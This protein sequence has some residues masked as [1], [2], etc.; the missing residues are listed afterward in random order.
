MKNGQTILTNGSSSSYVRT[1]M[2]I[3]L[4]PLDCLLTEHP[5]GDNINF[6]NLS[7]FVGR[8]GLR[9]LSLF[10]IV[11]GMDD[12]TNMGIAD[13][14]NFKAKYPQPSKSFL[15]KLCASDGVINTN[16]IK[17]MLQNTYN[18]Q[19]LKYDK[20][21]AWDGNNDK[22]T[23]LFNGNTLNKYKINDTVYVPISNIDW[24]SINKDLD[25]NN[26]PNTHNY[27]T[28][29]Y[30]N[31]S[32]D[33]IDPYYNENIFRIDLNYSNYGGYKS[34]M[35]LNN[36]PLSYVDNL[37]LEFDAKKYLERYFYDDGRVFVRKF[38]ENKKNVITYT[39]AKGTHT[40]PSSKS[41]TLIESFADGSD[42]ENNFNEIKDGEDLIKINRP[43]G[44]FSNAE[45]EISGV[46]T[47]TIPSFKGITY[48]NEFTPEY[49]I[50][51]QVKYYELD[52]NYAKAL[53]FLDSLKLK[54]EG[55]NFGGVR[56]DNYALDNDK[57]ITA[58][59]Q[60]DDEPFEIMPY[61]GLLLLGG[62]FWREQQ[63]IDPIK[64]FVK[65]SGA[66]KAIAYSIENSV[67]ELRQD[68]KNYLILEFKKWV[69]NEFKFYQEQFEI[70]PSIGESTAD[71]V[72]QLIQQIKS[73]K[74]N[75]VKYLYD[76]VS[77]TFFE[78]YISFK[79]SNGNL[80]LFNRET[81]VAVKML[82]NFYIQPCMV[83]KPTKYVS[84]KNVNYV[85][86]GDDYEKYIN[87]FITK[88]RE[89][90]Q[91]EYNTSK[92]EIVTVNPINTNEHI[93]ISLYKY[94][95]IL[96]DKWLSGTEESEW[97]LSK[98]YENN[99]Q[100]IDSYYN[101]VGDRT[102][103][104]IKQF[105]NDIIY[106]QKENGYSLLSFLSKTYA[107][108]RFAFH[109]V[110]NFMNLNN[111]KEDAKFQRL[112]DA[113]PYNEIDFN[114]INIHPSFIVM[115]TYEYSSKLDIEGG[116]YQDDSFDISS[117]SPK[118]LPTPISTK[119]L[120]NGYRVPAFGVTYGKQYQSYFKDI[121]ISMD[122]PMVTEQSIKAQFMIA[123]MH[124][125]NGE[126]GKK[127]D[128]LGQDLYTIYSNNSYTC[129]VKMMGCAWIQP[130]MYFQLFNV[131]MFRGAYLI[132]KVS[133]HIEPGNMETTFVG[134]RMAKTT[135]Q[136]VEKPL[137]LND[138]DQVPPYVSEIVEGAQ[139]EVTNDC[140]YKFFNPLLDSD[141]PRMTST[142]LG[143]SPTQ[144][145][146]Y[147][148]NTFKIPTANFSSIKQLIGS[149]VRSEAENQDKLG[150]QLVAT[151]LFNRYM[152]HGKDLTKVI[153]GKQH[154]Y[155]KIAYQNS[156][157]CTIAEDIFTKSPII[158]RGDMTKVS[159]QVPIL[160]QGQPNGLISEPITLTEHMLKSMDGYCT[161]RGYDMN[162]EG[163]AT[164]E[165]VGWWHN[166]KYVCQHDTST[167]A[168]GHVFVAGAYQ[169]G[170]TEYWQEFKENTTN[171]D[172][173]PSKKAKGLFE[174]I[175]ST[176]SFSNNIS[177]DNI[178]MEK[179]KY[180]DKDV[181]YITVTPEK[182]MID[183][184]DAIVNTYYDY[185]S[186]CNWIVKNDANEHPNK[187][188]VK[189]ENNATKR[190]ISI[191]KLNNN[192][193]INNLNQY[194]GLSK[195]FYTTLKKKYKSIDTNNKETFKVECPNFSTLISK[196]VD[197]MNKVNNLLGV[198]IKSCDGKVNL[199]TI[200]GYS[201]DGDN[202]PSNYG[203][204]T[205]P[206]NNDFNP[207]KAADYAKDNKT[208]DNKSIG[209]CATYVREAFQIG[210]G[211]GS[212]SDRPMSACAYSKFMEAW[213][214]TEVYRGFS[215]SIE[216]YSPQK[217]D[218]SV[219]AGTSAKPHGH[220][221]IYN[222]GLWY[223]DYGDKDAYCYNAD[224]GRPYIIYR[225]MKGGYNT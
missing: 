4:T 149:V 185:F 193:T 190:I 162:Y 141:S 142:E 181:F 54:E 145:E 159:R 73:D 75:I 81:S 102:Y 91:N 111:P 172:S 43:Y 128:F 169:K 7:D 200:D 44:L 134:T 121:N 138:N 42:Y 219:I 156:D 210:G 95:K 126:N 173:I 103:I 61:C 224:S 90:Y 130:L 205:I 124:G 1:V 108:S 32:S 62:Y 207:R 201:F 98:F 93:K 35:C 84:N 218:V 40:L 167:A 132:Q 20:K 27:I 129:T 69:D 47:F 161:T 135:T 26:N 96:Y 56:F 45:N 194:E 50:F 15:D 37:N 137:V 148:G 80:K 58:H 144:Y 3:P 13:A 140:E 31:H 67:F 64:S 114:N 163:N 131:P 215:P 30:I 152:Y 122:N 46:T 182:A 70:K 195:F 6:S 216:G 191:A 133:H 170:E 113:I 116:E 21:W 55:I 68:V 110:Q 155:E 206:F 211:A 160:V 2:E 139:A 94:I 28:T 85:A 86:I 104:N 99:W 5:F 192:G 16:V 57:N 8:I 220:I 151:V 77:D 52:S 10:G 78:N 19:E 184:F 150:Q 106:S 214:W 178:K 11:K 112:F 117:D 23:S 49:S 59:I 179:D 147:V 87:S 153:Y 146:K 168:L 221:Q 60:K 125:E 165:P 209:K 101:N 88:L 22:S 166:A 18:A 9:M 119:S 63:Q 118:Y 39:Y 76:N 199:P 120:S 65:E 157:F 174:A 217:G 180:G 154:A 71:F 225:W 197:W 12:Y 100:F 36:V 66:R 143:M 196:D 51:G 92:G 177:V 115:Y 186:E 223:S 48:N 158:L 164:K 79:E 53:V 222:D 212:M 204:P 171:D 25:S 14:I 187:I 127:I 41:E 202:S 34:K 74:K 123:S 188:R 72:K 29:N 109:C 83:I 208:P 213:G 175:K 24:E 183:T 89:L 82:T 107:T 33:K 198:T 105:C 97:S 136:M 17:N 189:A 38:S 203:K 176:V